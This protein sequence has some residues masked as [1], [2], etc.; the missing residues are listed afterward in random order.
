MKFKI[1]Q[2]SNLFFIGIGD[3]GGNFMGI[4]FWFFV[5]NNLEPENFGK[6]AF[7][8]G[9]ASIV[10]IIS[11]LGSGN[12]LSVLIAKKIPIISTFTLFRLI[13]SII[14]SFIL[15]L[16]FSNIELS[17][18]TFSLVIGSL[19][20]A[21]LTGKGK[22]QKFSIYNLGQKL[23]LF[24]LGFGTYF[25]FNQEYFLLSLGISYF[26]FLPVI[27]EGIRET[28]TNM[29]L[30]YEEKKFIFT[31]YFNSLLQSVRKDVDKFIIPLFLSISALGEFN[32]S[33]QIYSGLMMVPL[34]INRLII[35]EESS[36]KNTLKLLKH[37]ML[38]QFFICTIAFFTLPFMIANFFPKYIETL[39]MIPIISLSII[40][41]TFNI[42]VLT[43]MI[44]NKDN[45]L[46][47]II[48]LIQISVFISITIILGSTFGATG[49]GYAHLISYTIPSLIIIL[50]K[51]SY[52]Y[53]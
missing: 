46:I 9:V 24:L 42:L 27:I 29:T 10:S 16:I 23:L 43:K 19:G 47:M 36:G 14:L 49:L 41:A 34:V 33:I 21:I 37:T 35:F 13:I 2:N 25:F 20:Q 18:L 5:A 22:F 4:I 12:S 17:I 28:K 32:L 38:I 44:A 45:S 39:E 15:F 30:I 31:N 40:P 1:N 11:L 51:K 52:F 48:T 3:I 26:I 6:L 50:L 8:I 7:F 53:K